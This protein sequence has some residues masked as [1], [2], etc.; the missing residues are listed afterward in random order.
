[1]TDWVDLDLDEYEW[2]RQLSVVERIEG[3]RPKLI[4]LLGGEIDLEVIADGSV[5]V[6]ALGRPRFRAEIN[7]A[8]RLILTAILDTEGPLS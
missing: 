3:I 6:S 7:A 4:E 2:Q 1:M 5:E 8:G